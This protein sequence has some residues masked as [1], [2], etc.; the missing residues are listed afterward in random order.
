MV[1]NKKDSR[2]K[3]EDKKKVIDLFK[4]KNSEYEKSNC[5]NSNRGFDRL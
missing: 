3:W 2:R 1:L 4:Q 5:I